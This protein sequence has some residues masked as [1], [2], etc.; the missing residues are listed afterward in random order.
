MKSVLELLR[1]YRGIILYGVFGLLT[2]AVNTACYYLCF[3]V[4]TLPN[5]AS[6]AIA[7][8]IAVLFAFITNKMW[9]F[10]S[11][12]FARGVFFRE[13]ASFF[14]CRI[15]TGLLDMAIMYVA[16][17]CKGWNEMLWKLLA[18]IIVIVLNYAASKLLVFTKNAPHSVDE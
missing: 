12:S 11:K 6:T 14:S 10:D 5:L 15:A 8:L 13:L 2:T 17:D 3:D 9:V 4:L 1:R 18:N 7:W 16:V